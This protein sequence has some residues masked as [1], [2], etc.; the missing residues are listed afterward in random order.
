MDIYSF[1]DNTS[2]LFNYIFDSKTS[3]TDLRLIT[4]VP[5]IFEAISF[6]NNDMMERI[7]IKI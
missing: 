1:K 5:R 2:I 4:T 7:I 3:S 6:I